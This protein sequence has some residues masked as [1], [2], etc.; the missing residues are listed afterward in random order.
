LAWPQVEVSLS[1]RGCHYPKT[2]LRVLTARADSEAAL[3][4]VVRQSL[5]R[6]ADSP[7]L[8]GS[9]RVGTLVPQAA[10]L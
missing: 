4:E 2:N 1:G 7:E 10:M 6:V 3:D 8:A 5:D 9:L